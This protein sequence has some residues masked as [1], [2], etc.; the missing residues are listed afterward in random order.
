MVCGVELQVPGDDPD[1]G[2]DRAAGKGARK[3]A[4]GEDEDQVARRIMAAV[5][6]EELGRREALRSP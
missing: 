4:G 6:A 3:A 5:I 1:H 2:L